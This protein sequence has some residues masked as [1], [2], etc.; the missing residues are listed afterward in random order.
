MRALEEWRLAF[1]LGTAIAGAALSV[2]ILAAFAKKRSA[3]LA[4]FL[5]FYL[6]GVLDMAGAFISGLARL[7]ADFAF[8]SIGFWRI[9]LA[10]SRSRYVF[11]VL[12]AHS[13]HKYRFTGALSLAWIILIIGA[14]VISFL[15]YTLIPEII[16]I[17]VVVY[18]FVYWLSL[19]IL[20]DR[21]GLAP[22]IRGLVRA[23]LLCSGFFMIGIL[24]DLLQGIPQAG[25]YISIL[26]IDF[27]PLYLVCLGIVAAVW[28]VRASSRASA[29]AE[30][31]PGVS[32]RE[33]EIIGLILEGRTNREIA[34]SLFIS[35]STVKKHVN[36]IFKKLRIRSR[37]ALVR[38]SRGSD[39]IHP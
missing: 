2:I 5:A 26:L 14:I 32:A 36:H 37:W 17:A 29:R 18:C 31:R 21:L 9:G 35:E 38:L 6:L 28:A 15:V 8:D 4:F 11:L 22:D 3:T 7:R 33:S 39:G 23:V 10:A 12:F 25:A 16:E 34:E 30:A 1:S 27:T 20:K 13:V 19:D 24:L